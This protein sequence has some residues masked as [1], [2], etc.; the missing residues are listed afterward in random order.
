MSSGHR[1]RTRGGWETVLIPAVGLPN[2][3]SALLKHKT[4]VHPSRSP[5]IWKQPCDSIMAS[6]V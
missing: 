5:C 3:C 4:S 6:K 1:G 2:V